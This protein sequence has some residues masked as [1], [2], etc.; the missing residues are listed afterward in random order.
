MVNS[1]SSFIWTKARMNGAADARVT[2]SSA[3][4][5]EINLWMRE[6]GSRVDR[7]LLTQSSSTPIG[8]GPA[9]STRE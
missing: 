8:A 6:D 9:E 7:I 1:C 2:V 5:N 4:V 3:G